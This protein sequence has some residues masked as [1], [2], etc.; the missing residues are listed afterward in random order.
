MIQTFYDLFGKTNVSKAD[1]LLI[2][3]HTLPADIAQK[4]HAIINTP[5]IIKAI[6]NQ[7]KKTLQRAGFIFHKTFCGNIIAEHPELPG[8]VIKGPRPAAIRT[9]GFFKN[10]SR[11]QGAQELQAV[12]KELGHEDK[13]VVPKKYFFNY[14]GR[15]THLDDANYCIFAEKIALT[16]TPLTAVPAATQQALLEVIKKAKF[17]DPR[18]TNFCVTNT[19]KIAIVDTEKFSLTPW[20]NEAARHFFSTLYKINKVHVKQAFTPSPKT[21]GR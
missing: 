10:I 19:G 15:G 21:L 14:D 17:F 13:I 8:W 18:A 2:K 9:I 5:A 20:I 6:T 4:A 3:H 11:V 12:I 16:K 1:A 7:H